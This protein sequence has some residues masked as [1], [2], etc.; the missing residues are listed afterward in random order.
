MTACAPQELAYAPPDEP[1]PAFTGELIR[2]LEHGIPGAPDPLPM[3]AVFRQLRDA[4]AAKQ[5]PR[6][7]ASAINVGHE[8]AL[9]RNRARTPPPPRTTTAPSPPAAPA[10]HRWWRRPSLWLPTGPP[11]DG[12]LGRVPLV[13]LLTGSGNETGIARP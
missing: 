3:D 1:Y 13:P 12:V 10:A 5:R 9:A 11:P 6:P 7:Q 8:I 4:L 2:T